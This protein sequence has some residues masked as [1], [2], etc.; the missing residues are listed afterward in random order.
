MHSGIGCRVVANTH[1]RIEPDP[2]QSCERVVSVDE[3]ALRAFKVM[4]SK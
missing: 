2:M 1:I 3:A 4:K